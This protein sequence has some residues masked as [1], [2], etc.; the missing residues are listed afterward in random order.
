MKCGDERSSNNIITNNSANSNNYCG[1]NVWNSNNNTVTANIANSNDYYG[2]CL[3]S[4]SN[5]IIYVN[6]FINNTD[7]VYSYNSTNIWNSTEQIT[8]TYNRKQ[9]TNYLGNYWDDYNGSD[10]DGDGIGD[11][12]YSM[13]HDKD[14]YPLVEPFENYF[15]TT[16]NIFDT[17]APSNPYPSIAGTHN[18]TIIPSHD[19]NITKL[20]TY[21]C[22]G[23]GGHTEYAALYHSNGTLIAEAYWEGYQGDWHNITFNK[24]FVLLL[25]ET[26]N[27]IIRTG[28]YP[29]IIHARSK[30]VTGGVINCTE[31]IDAN[32]KKYE[33]WIPAIKLYS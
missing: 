6:N 7:N 33:D 29:Q 18:G 15:L 25:G 10:A 9:Y 14:Y 16:E 32:G 2:I 11:T 19:I 3:T 23:T 12:S 8:Y 22:P 20:Y 13:D 1:I 4:S 28:S 21:P 17:G 31:F 26:Y 5:N 27:Y 30:D 24:T